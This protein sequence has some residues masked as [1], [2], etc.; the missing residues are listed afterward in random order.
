MSRMQLL[1][2]ESHARGRSWR[3]DLNEDVRLRN[4]G[5]QP[6]Q[7]LRDLE[8]ERD[9]LLASIRPHEMRRQPIDSGI[10]ATR[11]I[12]CTRPLD[13][14]DARPEVGELARA[15]RCRDRMLERDDCDAIEGPGHAALIPD[16]RMMGIQR[17]YSFSMNARVSAG[18]V[19]FGLAPSDTSLAVTAGFAMI[20]CRAS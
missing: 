15:E 9:A 16:S 20:F 11:E 10:V 8:I 2:S 3:K 5:L 12:A 14:D 7:L 17:L 19:R 1:E 4:E 18:D 13:L 6:L